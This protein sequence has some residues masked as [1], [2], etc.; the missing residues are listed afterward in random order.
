MYSI[1][2]VKAIYDKSI[3]RYGYVGR[4]HLVEII[5][6]FLDLQHKMVLLAKSPDDTC[7]SQRFA[8]IAVN[9]GSTDSF[10]SFHLS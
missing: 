3:P 1:F 10:Y 6:P 5:Y 8:E 7:T 4:V 9:R 2:V